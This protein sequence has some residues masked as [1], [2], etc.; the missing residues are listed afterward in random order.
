MT[1]YDCLVSPGL[2]YT[3]CEGCEGRGE[4]RVQRETKN[5]IIMGPCF[6]QPAALYHG[7]RVRKDCISGLIIASTILKL[8][9]I[10]RTPFRIGV[11]MPN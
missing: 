10:F 7:F 2:I 8:V 5:I 3:P 6:V 4:W 9:R 1:G 11:L